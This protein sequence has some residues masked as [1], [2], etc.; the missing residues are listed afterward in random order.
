MMIMKIIKIL[1]T[2][3]ILCVI[4]VAFGF[5]IRS[6]SYYLLLIPTFLMYIFLPLLVVLNL[7]IRSKTK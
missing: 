1:I 3:I 7:V 4:S 2:I 5:K 6:I